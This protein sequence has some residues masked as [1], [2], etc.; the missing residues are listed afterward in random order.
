MTATDTRYNPANEV[1]KYKFFEQ[2]GNGFDGKDPKTVD[3]FVN[4]LHEFEIATGFKDFTKYTSDWAIQFKN[5]LNDKKS[6]R[7]GLEV[8]KSLYF[9]YINFVRRFFEWAVDNEKDY[10]KLNRREVDFLHVT[11]NDKNKARVT[12]YQESHDVA[13]IL[14]TI[15]NMPEN[16]EMERR[17]KAIVSLFLLTTPRI[18][19]LQQARID[20]I[21]YF[22]DYEIWALIQDPRLQNIKYA[23]NITTFFIGDSDDII[24]NIIRW[25]DYLVA[26]GLSGKD[27]LFPKITPSFTPD[28][29]VKAEISRDYI[30]SSTQIRDIIKEAF[31]NNGL[32]YLKPH[33]FRHSIARKVRKEPDATNR[34]IALAEN[35]G[36]KNGMAILVTSYAGDSLGQ[37]AAII[38]GIKLE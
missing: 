28:G 21:K 5:H 37:R 19:S 1:V 4:A 16:T 20:R 27:Y 11:R 26:K 9:H 31:L 38:K 29:V 23:K 34:L 18:G 35:L 3:Q 22:K 33:S 6:A 15:R 13:D 30:K 32:Q 14:A 8:S 10:A 17:N 24:Q 12:N 2:L 7:T 36:Q 25:R